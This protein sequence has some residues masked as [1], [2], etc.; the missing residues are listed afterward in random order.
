MNTISDEQIWSYVEANIE[1]FHEKRLESLNQ[2]R[3]RS[4][5]ERKN[6]YL[7]KS[8]N[9][10][11]AADLV[12]SLL[13]AHLSSQE[14]TMFGD[15]LEGLAIYVAGIVHGGQKSAALGAIDLEFTKDDIR[16]II[17]IKSGPNWGNSSQIAEM[18]DNFVTATR[19]IRQ[20]NRTANVIAV[21]GCCYGRDN[22]PDKGGYFKYCG[23]EFW[24]L[25][26]GDSNLYT[27]IVEPLGHNAKQRNQAFAEQYA[28]V[29]NR[30]SQ[31]FA[32][33]YCTEDG[34]IDWP[35]VVA[36]SSEKRMS[37]KE[38]V[39]LVT[40]ALK[41]I[42]QDSDH[43]MPVADL[44]QPLVE[45]GFEF[46]GA[47]PQEAVARIIRQDSRFRFQRRKPRGWVLSEEVDEASG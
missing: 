10:V 6:P 22:N 3:L 11:V 40:E 47:R 26:S 8:K 45:R 15:F 39:A 2:Q 16:Y 46:G 4:L 43:P 37:R 29:V 17:D 36:V 35:K 21:N 18:K 27:R 31:Q 20:G 7:F 24:E 32:A 25:I 1:S 5:L 34:S 14:E 13:D 33:E 12:R 41:G 44:L 23:Q 42:I 30:M 38:F 19:I 28:A 9:I